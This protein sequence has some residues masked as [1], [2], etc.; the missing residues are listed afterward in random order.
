MSTLT[1]LD[2]H[3]LVSFDVR[4]LFTCIPQQLAIEAVREALEHDKDLKNRTKLKKEELVNL[5]DLCV[6]SNYF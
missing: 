1:L 6:N 3:Q 4:N 2:D 5:V